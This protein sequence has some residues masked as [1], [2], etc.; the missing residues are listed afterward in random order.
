MARGEAGQVWRL[1][2][3]RGMWAV[4]E[5]FAPQSVKQ[6]SATGSYQEHL[7]L[8]GIPLPRILRDEDGAYTRQIDGV[9]VRVFEWVELE[10]PD[11]GLDPAEVGAVVASIHRAPFPARGPIAAW[12]T[13]PLGA[14]RWHELVRASRARSAPFADRL[15]EQVT[16]WIAVEKVLRPMRPV[17]TCHLDMWADNFRRTTSGEISVIDWDQAGPADPCREVAMVLFEFGRYDR[18]RL[19]TLQAAY[20]DAGGP[21]AV[22]EAADFSVAVA[23]FAHIG[24][25]HLSMWLA[26]DATDAVKERAVRGI[27]ELLDAPLDLATIALILDAVT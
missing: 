14:A 25:R 1:T 3:D 9:F 12:H 5:S 8:H 7:S 23:Q 17:Q 4:K 19:R 6:A 20:V 24:E 15:A 13:E 26:P 10:Q 16:D 18:E 27:D 21:A 11:S 22:K 2:T